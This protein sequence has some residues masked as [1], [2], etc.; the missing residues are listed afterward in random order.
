MLQK[1]RVERKRDIDT[2]EKFVQAKGIVCQAQTIE[3]RVVEIDEQEA[4]LT[5]QLSEA[6][7]GADRAAREVSDLPELIAV[8]QRRHL[9]AR[10]ELVTWAFHVI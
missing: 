4:A 9:A 10:E 3:A 1:T 5:R 7:A 2:V 8:T 6:R